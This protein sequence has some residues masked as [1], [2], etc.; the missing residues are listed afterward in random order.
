MLGSKA[1]T[2]RFSMTSI[3]CDGS[4]DNNSQKEKH[5]SKDKTSAKNK[6]VQI[7]VPKL[8]IKT[9]KSTFDNSVFKD[10]MNKVN[11]SSPNSKKFQL[12][13]KDSVL[14]SLAK[15]S[16]T[17]MEVGSNMRPKD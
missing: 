1:Q 17:G 14:S 4:S 8:K 11:I 15:L 2:T 13:D 9:I 7:E 12:T 6:K 16:T 5:T 10:Q 3:S